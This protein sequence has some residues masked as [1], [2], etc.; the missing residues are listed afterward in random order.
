MRP[1]NL[2]PVQVEDDETG[3]WPR[4]ADL[5]MADMQICSTSNLHDS[6]SACQMCTG[7]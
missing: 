5:A 3:W 4:T 2:E 1:G 7:L 6:V